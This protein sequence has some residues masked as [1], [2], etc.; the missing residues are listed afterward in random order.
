MKLALA[1]NYDPELLPQVKPYG[2]TEIYGKL[3]YDV[4]GGGR[5]SY[6]ATPMGKD[7]LAAYVAAFLCEWH[8]C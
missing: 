1:A 5:P 7:T 4:V 8:R 3:P 2:V 6:M